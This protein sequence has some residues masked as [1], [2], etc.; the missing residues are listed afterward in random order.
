MAEKYLSNLY[1]KIFR[2]IEALSLVLKVESN[3]V[4]RLHVLD[5][6]VIRSLPKEIKV[7][8]TWIAKPCF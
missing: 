7:I 2:D 6:D 5:Y 4:L 3:I 1:Q 8:E